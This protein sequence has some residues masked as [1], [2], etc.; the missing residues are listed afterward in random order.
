MVIDRDRRRNFEREGLRKRE[1]F[2]ENRERQKEV[3]RYNK[4]NRELKEGEVRERQTERQ[5]ESKRDRE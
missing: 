2:R 3:V 1:R 4:C 5:S